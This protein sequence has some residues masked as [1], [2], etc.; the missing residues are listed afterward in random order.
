MPL[1]SIFGVPHGSRNILKLGSNEDL[2][3]CSRKVVGERFVSCLRVRVSFPPRIISIAPSFTLGNVPQC[4]ESDFMEKYQCYQEPHHVCSDH[5]L[6]TSFLSPTV[7]TVFTTLSVDLQKKGRFWWWK[8]GNSQMPYFLNYSIQ[9]TENH[10]GIEMN[11]N[12]TWIC[13]RCTQPRGLGE[14]ERGK[15]NPDLLCWR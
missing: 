13:S 1:M 2:W 14:E 8:L 10:R 6:R 9:L 5:H 11:N 3:V 4:S 12:W 7:F 15:K